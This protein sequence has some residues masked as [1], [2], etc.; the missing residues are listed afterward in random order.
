MYKWKVVNIGMQ[1][2]SIKNVICNTV[3]IFIFRKDN[4]KVNLLLTLVQLTYK[5]QSSQN[6]NV[7]QSVNI[8]IFKNIIE[9]TMAPL[10]FLS[11][12]NHAR[13]T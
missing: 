9:H 12:D 4:I 11:K 6:T 13:N 1:F 10:K 8:N 2:D 5:S 7:K 3:Y